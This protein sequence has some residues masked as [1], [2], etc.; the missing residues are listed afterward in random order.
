MLRWFGSQTFARATWRRAFVV[1]A[2]AVAALAL[3]DG[4]S[5]ATLTYATPTLTYTGVATAET[6]NIESLS[7]TSVKFFGMAVGQITAPLPAGC[8]LDTTRKTDQIVTCDIP[9]LNHISV[10]LGGGND[11]LSESGLSEESDISGGDGD[12]SIVGG[13]AADTINGDAGI[14]KVNGGNGNDTIVSQ[15]GNAESINCGLGVDTETGD[16]T[17]T[18]SGCEKTT[19]VVVDKDGDGYSPPADC[20]DS[21]ADIHPGATDIP[22]DGI[23]QD[24]S[25][26]DAVVPTGSGATGGSGTTG[27]SSGGNGAGGTATTTGGGSAGTGL[28]NNNP[29][30]A[31]TTPSTSSTSSSGVFGVNTTSGTKGITI[32]NT[33]TDATG[34]TVPGALIIAANPTITFRLLRARHYTRASKLTVAPVPAGATVQ[35]TCKGAGCPKKGYRKTFSAGLDHLIVR[36]IFD[37]SKLRAGATIKARVTKPGVIGRAM[38]YTVN[39]S[40]VPDAEASCLAPGTGLRTTC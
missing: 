30:V 20:D 13:S 8:A 38:T 35:V 18:L 7:T 34:A 26:A 6:V 3:P 25:G 22:G 28:A 9:D 2:C 4:A 36:S 5:A 37:L 12:D 14:D 33:S 10:S 21:R 31:P 17:D 11:T 39:A 40:A 27:S 1:V 23:D 32:T 19:I 29:V 15:D 24:C 16:N